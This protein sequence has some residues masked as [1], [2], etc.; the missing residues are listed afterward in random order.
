M[1][2]FGLKVFELA[3]RNVWRNRRRSQVTIAAMSFGLLVMILYAAL[4]QGYLQMMERNIVELEVGDVQIF[5]GDYR[6]APS[7]HTRID[8]PDSVLASLDQA[9]FPASHDSRAQ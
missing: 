4:M 5:A 6:D 9:G 3:W 1:N 8:D 2:V 7:I